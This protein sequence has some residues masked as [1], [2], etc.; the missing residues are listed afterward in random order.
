[1]Y[2]DYTSYTTVYRED[3]Y[4]R[5]AMNQFIASTGLAKE[6][7]DYWR[8][9]LEQIYADN[10]GEDFG[11]IAEAMAT[12]KKEIGAF[13]SAE[14]T[15]LVESGFTLRDVFGYDIP[16]SA[17]AAKAMMDSFG[18]SGEEAMN[19][20]A[21]GAQDVYKRQDIKWEGLS[22]QGRLLADSF[23][24]GVCSVANTYGDKFVRII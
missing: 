17:R 20:I 11:D 5:Q 13:D 23:F 4:K 8:D 19:L 1:M 2:G 7:T 10:Y 9:S 15:N 14:L 18:I 12:V 16:E 22:E 24:I 3:V 21:A 6:G